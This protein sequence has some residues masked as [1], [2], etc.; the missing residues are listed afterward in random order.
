MS[1]APTGAIVTLVTSWV[2]LMGWPVKVGMMAKAWDY[3]TSLAAPDGPTA[4]FCFL[5]DIDECA[6]PSG[7]H[8]CSYSC[9][10]VPGSYYCTCPPTGYTLAPDRQTCLGLS[11]SHCFLCNIFG[12]LCH[13]PPFFVFQ[14]SMSV[15][16]ASTP[17]LPLKAALTFREDS[18]ACPSVVRKTFMK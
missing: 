5:S 2:A 9:S 3:P 8:A 6:P 15:L 4:G 14:I 18:A 13:S 12:A 11:K 7:G 10:N 16:Q 1:T 17:V